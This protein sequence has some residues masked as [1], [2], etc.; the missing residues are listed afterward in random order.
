MRS[1][2]RGLA[3]WTKNSFID[4][5][6]TVST[7]LFFSGCNLR[8]PYCHNCVFITNPEDISC[9]SNEIWDFLENRRKVI[10]GVVFTGGEPTL[11]PNIKTLINEIRTLK[12]RVMLDTNGLLP[13]MI[14]NFSPDYLAV[15]IKTDPKLY[16]SLLKAPF[17]NVEKRLKHSLDI[18]KGMGD[19]AEVRITVAPGIITEEII[20]NLRP[21]LDGV[22]K[23][24]LQPVNFRQEILDSAF[25][26]S[27]SP[28][29][30][31]EITYFQELLSSVVG[32][33]TI[34]NE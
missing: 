13:E 32:L 7:V 25:F 19:N 29:P 22:Q 12:Y 31:D 1:N 17:D 23:V 14:E 30:A 21:L 6:G 5:P 20:C 9:R 8:C 18:L 27:L 15:D 11:H 28:T 24:F 2:F 34:R 3:G 16:P 4:F 10:E 26:P 33:C